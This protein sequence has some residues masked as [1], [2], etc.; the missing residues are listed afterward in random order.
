MDHLV[1]HIESLIFTA[2]SPIAFAEIRSCLQT[3]FD[4]KIKKP[5][6]QKALD[7]LKEKY[8]QEEFSFELVEIG[9][10]YQFLTKAAFHN[11]VG[12]YLKQTTKKRL[13]KAALETLSIIAY[14][15]PVPKSEMEKIRGVSCDYS[16][17]KLLEKELITILGRADGPG[18]PLLYGTSEKF[19]DYFGLKD[20]DALPKP[21]DF[22]EPD[23]EIGEKA[24]IDE[25]RPVAE[26]TPPIEASIPA[27]PNAGQ[28]IIQEEAGNDWEE[29]QSPVIQEEIPPS[30]GEVDIVNP[31]NQDHLIEEVIPTDGVDLSEDNAETPTD[32]EELP[33]EGLELTLP[34]EEEI[35]EEVT[36]ND[37]VHLPEDNAETPT[38]TE[39]LPPEGLESNTPQEEKVEEEVTPADNTNFT[40]ATPVYIPPIDIKP[41]N[42][43]EESISETSNTEDSIE[44][45]A[46]TIE[47]DIPTGTPANF[48]PSTFTKEPSTTKEEKITQPDSVF[49][50]VISIIAPPLF[51][52][53]KTSQEIEDENMVNGD[54]TFDD[55]EV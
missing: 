21:K 40:P 46:T 53:E 55:F 18:K 32:T 13:S 27:P 41:K 24:P 29:P 51:F 9:G 34:Q 15:Q 38:N 52:D 5:P 16:V 28:E 4:I 1:Q 14:K 48:I 8:Q 7:H 23:N 19:M 36:P 39:E 2:E 35:E 12:V 22:K 31:E 33:P 17:Q 49:Q 37:G 54:T 3:S 45:M 20:I 47:E 50:E 25:D 44:E 30:S 11:T 43:E 42:E 26:E 6:I 10:G